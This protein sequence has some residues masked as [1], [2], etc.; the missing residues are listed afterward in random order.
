M[1]ELAMPASSFLQ[2]FAILDTIEL[3]ELAHPTN[4]LA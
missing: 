1:A 2:D 3:K 4:S